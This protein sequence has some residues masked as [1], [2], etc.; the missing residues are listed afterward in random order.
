MNDMQVVESN[1]LVARQY[2]DCRAELAREQAKVKLLRRVVQEEVVKQSFNSALLMALGGLL[3]RAGVQAQIGDAVDL[4][5]KMRF[6]ESMVDRL[7]QALRD[8]E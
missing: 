7:K 3:Q 5:D 8:T 2:L 4:V 1:I 6:L